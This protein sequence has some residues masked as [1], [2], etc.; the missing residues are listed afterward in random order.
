MQLC[1][2]GQILPQ[3]LDNDKGLHTI[4]HNPYLII[5][6]LLLITYII[7]VFDGLYV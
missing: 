1:N 7:C 5:F 3:L 2:Y 6:T 4:L